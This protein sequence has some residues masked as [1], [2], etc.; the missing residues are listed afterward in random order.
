MCSCRV[1]EIDR[2]LRIGGPQEM[3]AICEQRCWN[4]HSA[5]ILHELPEKLGET[6]AVCGL[7]LFV[8]RVRPDRVHRRHEALLQLDQPFR[9]FPGELANQVR[10]GIHQ[11]L[12]LFTEFCPLIQ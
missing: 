2:L 5:G 11:A 7:V 10:R 6:C 1:L 4:S 8:L 12:H 9:V 3:Q